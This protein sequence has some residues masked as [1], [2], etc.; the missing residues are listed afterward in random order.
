[1]ATLRQAGRLRHQ[2][3]RRHRLG[4]G[5]TSART[6]SGIGTGAVSA[7]ARCSTR[8][9]AR[10]VD[11]A[12]TLRTCMTATPRSQRA[13]NQM[14]GLP[15]PNETAVQEHGED[16]S[17]CRAPTGVGRGL[18]STPPKPVTY[19][20][21]CRLRLPSLGRDFAPAHTLAWRAR[22][23]HRDG[24]VIVGAVRQSVRR[25]ELARRRPDDIQTHQAA[26][27]PVAR[28]RA[29]RSRDRQWQRPVLKLK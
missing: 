26:R 13:G 20:C 16:R 2:G 29:D 12:F 17:R 22:R 6:G 21:V 18:T 10:Q 11:S 1:M 28:R 4:T 9:G 3:A 8:F 5:G 25:D 24:P 23:N 15:P 14:R 19:G 7:L 27:F